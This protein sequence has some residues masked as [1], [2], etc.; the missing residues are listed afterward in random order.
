MTM[1]DNYVIT[2][3]HSM[4]SNGTTN[5]DSTS[6][7]HYYVD[8]AKELG[9][10]AFAFSEHGNIFAWLKKKEY[11]E[12]QGMKYIHAVEAYLTQ[13]SYDGLWIY[14][15]NTRVNKSKNK[16]ECNFQTVKNKIEFIDKFNSSQYDGETCA[17][18]IKSGEKFFIDVSTIEK[19][20]LKKTD[21]NYHII[22][23]ARNYDGVK[24]INLLT[25][26]AY[27]RSETNSHFYGKPRIYIDDL[28]KTSDNV[29]VT[30]ACLGGVFNKGT[31][32]IKERLLSFMI[33]NKD[34]C[35]FEIQ[36][37]N[38]KEQIEYNKMLYELS[39]STG[40]KL[41]VGTDTHEV[42]EKRIRAR[43]VLQLAKDVYFEGEDDFDL[44][45]RS[46]DELIDLYKK[47][48]SLPIE[49][50]KQALEQ[51][52]IIADMV[53]EFRDRKSVV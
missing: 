3:C 40:I 47:Q 51:T 12:K 9:M 42:E 36:H 31:P 35:F 2:H 10:K 50:V 8:K 52:N 23:I 33:E 30:S 1:N 18:D 15:A 13:D 27:D 43:R 29:I 25:S 4:L 19:S 24:E 28:V 6:D 14:K 37:H 32:E 5:V 11:I 49:V 22:L 44:V 21:D 38:C 34:R 41:V 7:F 53:E 26:N 48:N 45:M 16:N 39:K 46:Y 20:R 17:L